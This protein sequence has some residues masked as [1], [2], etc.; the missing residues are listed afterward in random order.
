[1]AI[2]PT[3]WQPFA[4]DEERLNY[5]KEHGLSPKGAKEPKALF[6]SGIYAE[7]TEPCT[8]EGTAGDVTLVI[9]VGEM[10]HCIHPDY[11]AEMQKGTGRSRERS[12]GSRGKRTTP[13]PAG[14][15]FVAIDFETA[16][17]SYESACS[18]GIAVVQGLQ[19]TET[20]YG[21]LQPPQNRYEEGN[22]RIHGITPAQT[23]DAPTL[24]QVWPQISR[25]FEG[26]LVVAHNARFDT[27]VLRSS[28]HQSDSIPNFKWA[29]TVQMVKNIVPGRHGL[30]ACCA[31]FGISL[32]HHHNALDDAVACANV[33]ISCART[34]GCESVK[35]FLKQERFSLNDFHRR[36]S[37]NRYQ[38]KSVRL[39]EVTATVEQFDLSHPL[40]QKTL[41]FTGD[42]S[43]D[44]AEAVQLAVNKGALV[45]SG[46]S[47]KT[48]VVVLGR[49][50]EGA[51]MSSKEKR[52]RELIAAGKE[53]RLLE[54]EEFLALVRS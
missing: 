50:E 48:Q 32:E 5:L 36:S 19:V 27:S 10:Y 24:D 3:N 41:V 37:Y 47:G 13:R 35:A 49:R 7:G 6:Y 9:R 34:V 16:T 29:D 33:A 53:I 15:D 46:V 52:A 30:D 14:V 4:S 11:L 26:N 42:L 17:G 18:L 25:F 45:K 31:Y 23:A 40:Y 54:E 39:S 8:A 20:W 43:I 28:L 38:S 51:P 22:V 12:A 1:M 21:L 2:Q 44:R